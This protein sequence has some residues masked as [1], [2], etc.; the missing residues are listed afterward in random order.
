MS[1]SIRPWVSA[2]SEIRF[3]ISGSAVRSHVHVVTLVL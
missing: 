2:I 1:T 3:A